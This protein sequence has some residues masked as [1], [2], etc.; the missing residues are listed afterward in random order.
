MITRGSLEALTTMGS[1]TPWFC[2]F[3]AVPEFVS[4]LI[5]PASSCTVS[6]VSMPITLSGK[7]S[8]VLALYTPLEIV[9]NTASTKIFPTSSS[10]NPIPTLPPNPTLSP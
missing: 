7:P 2:V 5:V 9:G 4:S 3:A 8:G 6:S 10:V 1:G